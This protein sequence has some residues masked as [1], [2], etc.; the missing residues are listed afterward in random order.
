M[1]FCNLLRTIRIRLGYKVNDAAIA[2]GVGTCNLC[3]YETGQAK[4]SISTLFKFEAAYDLPQGVLIDMFNNEDKRKIYVSHPL[5]NGKSGAELLPMVEHNRKVV[6]EICKN[7]LQ[8]HKDIL[9]LSPIHA[10][11][12]ISPLGNQT[13]AFDQC[14]AMLELA[15]ELWVYGDWQNSEGCRMEIKYAEILKIPIMYIYADSKLKG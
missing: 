15:D 1:K 2:C 5:R 14:R 12:F 13:A 11:G 8:R 7:I 3:A 6:S 9:I 10:F 4:P